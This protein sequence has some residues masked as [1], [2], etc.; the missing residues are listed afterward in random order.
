MAFASRRGPIR[1]HVAQVAPAA[2][3]NFLNT[4]HSIARITNTPDMGFVIGLKETRPPRPR[5]ELRAR[6]EERQ[7]AKA[8]GVNAI[9]VIVEKHTTEGSFRAVLE[10]HALLVLIKARGDLRALRLSWGPQVK[11]IHRG[12]S[13]AVALHPLF[14]SEPFSARQLSN[15]VMNIDAMRQ[16]DFVFTKTPPHLMGIVEGFLPGSPTVDSSGV[17]STATPGDTLAMRSSSICG[18]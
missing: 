8:A 3:A 18:S 2:R 13:R 12:C 10:Q 14:R 16:P 9:L 4:D 17:T 1:K 11:A 5:I 7:A 6:P 15:G